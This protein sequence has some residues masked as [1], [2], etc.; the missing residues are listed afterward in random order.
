MQGF[1]KYNLSKAK[2]IREFKIK[3]RQQISS[4]NYAQSTEEGPFQS[5]KSNIHTLYK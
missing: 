5:Q 3:V 4:T 1:K 2:T